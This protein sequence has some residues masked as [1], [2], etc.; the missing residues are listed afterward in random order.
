MTTTLIRFFAA[1]AALLPLIAS[2]ADAPGNFVTW[3]PGLASSAQPTAAWLEKVK[4]LKYDVVVNLAPPQ[5]HGSIANEAAIVG[6]KGVP[7]V[8]IPVNFGKPTAEEFRFFSEVLRANASRNV[9]VHCQV[10]M[11]GSAFVFLYRVI[12]E[13]ASVPES[14]A[15]LTGVW[16]PDPVW[17]Q[18]I[19]QTLAAHGKRAEIL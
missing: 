2:A 5:S 3:R 14:L 19:E 16:A 18:F 9:F 11:R 10:N 12:H 4:D 8:N 1:T 17:K 13:G 7:Y 15:K 6:S